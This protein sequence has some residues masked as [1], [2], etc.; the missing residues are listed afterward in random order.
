MAFLFHYASQT[1]HRKPAAA[2][3]AAGYATLAEGPKNIFGCGS[4]RIPKTASLLVKRKRDTCG[5]GSPLEF[6]FK[7]HVVLAPA[8]ASQADKMFVFTSLASLSLKGG[9]LPT[10]KK[11]Y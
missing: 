6:S 7:K 3:I 4:K 1:C 2:Q 5:C 9:R 10:R 8:V 11:T